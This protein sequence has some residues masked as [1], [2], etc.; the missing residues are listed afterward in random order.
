MKISRHRLM[1]II[2]E[3]YDRM[4]DSE[5]KECLNESVISEASL[6]QSE[7]ALASIESA[8]NST[9]SNLLKSFVPE[10]E[11]KS[12]VDSAADAVSNRVRVDLENI[13]DERSTP[14]E[15]IV[16]TQEPMDILEELRSLTNKLSSISGNTQP[17]ENIASDMIIQ[18]NDLE[19]ILTTENE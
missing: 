19:E 15:E 1:Q 11:I 17:L 13:Y 3:E 16:M 10:T 6:S 12:M 8:I 4:L 9:L 5:K 7:V 14:L 18:I 2:Q